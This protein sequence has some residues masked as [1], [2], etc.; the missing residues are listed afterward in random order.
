MRRLLGLAL[1]ASVAV[2]AITAAT[3]LLA[4]RPSLPPATL[5]IHQDGWSLSYPDT[6]RWYPSEVN[7]HYS[8]LYGFLSSQLVDPITVCSPGERGLNC[9][10]RGLQVATGKL[11]LEV[12]WASPLVGL[13]PDDAWLRPIDGRPTRI[14]GAPAIEMQHTQDD[15]VIE[16]WRIKQRIDLHSWLSIEATVREPFGT[17]GVAAAAAIVTS[18]RWDE[19]L[20]T[21]VPGQARDIAV[22]ALDDVRSREPE[23]YACFPPPGEKKTVTTTWLPSFAELK[24]PLIVTCSTTI[25]AT[26]IDY[27]KLTITAS[28]DAAAGQPGGSTSSTLWLDAAGQLTLTTGGGGAIPPG[29][30]KPD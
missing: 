24:E 12:G 21:I 25:V 6:F 8:G 30:C 11:I 26:E 27:W 15:L 7:N 3:N 14:D 4:P 19:P 22:R 23:A 1:I 2:L 20:P 18:F 10:L 29:C 28:W 16:T 17:Q 9:D 5:L 13:E